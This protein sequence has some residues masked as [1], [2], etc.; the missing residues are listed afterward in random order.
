[1]GLWI[2]GY[3]GELGGMDGGLGLFGLLLGRR[4]GRVKRFKN[5]GGRGALGK[6]D[7]AVVMD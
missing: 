2:L 7:T 1:M 5:R 6:D 4:E 3:W